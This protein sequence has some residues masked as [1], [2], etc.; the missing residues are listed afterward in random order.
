MKA[1]VADEHRD[2]TKQKVDGIADGVFPGVL[3]EIV[4]P[5][6]QSIQDIGNETGGQDTEEPFLPRI[7]IVFKP[8][9]IIFHVI[10]PEEGAKC[11]IERDVNDQEEIP[12]KR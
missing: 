2:Y 12:L 3:Q 1:A 6:E 8:V 4:G 11:E 7:E 10:R 9:V 5:F